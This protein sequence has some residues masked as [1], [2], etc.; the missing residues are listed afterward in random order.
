VTVDAGETDAGNDFI[1][2]LPATISGSIF[3]DTDN[4]DVGEDLL[5]G[6]TVSLFADTNGDGVPDGTALATQEATDGTYSFTGLAPGSYVVVETQPSGY[7]TVSDGDS[8]FPDTG[9]TADAANSSPTDNQIPVTVDAGETDAGNDFIEELPATIS[10]SIF[11]DTDND[12]VGEDLLPGVT[13]SLFADTNGDGVP[14]GSA[15]ATQEATDGTYSFTGLA[16]GDYVVVETQPSGYLTVS[17]EDST[18]GGDDLANVDTTDNLIPVSVDAG[19][20]D[21][22]N[23]FIEELPAAISGSIY[24]DTDNDDVGEDLLPG[25]TVSLFADTNGDGVPDGSALATQEAT[26]GT[27]SFTGLAPGSYVVVETQPSGYLTVSDGDSELPDTGTTADAANS[28]PTDN[29]IPVTVDAGETDAGNDFIEELPATI[30]GSIYADTNNDDVGEDLLPGVT[31][32]LFADTNGDGVPDGSALATQESTD[33]TY[34]FTGLAAGSYV[35][36]E[37]QPSGYLTVS[38]GDS[39]LPDTGTT[40]DAANSSP[41]DNQIPVTVDAGETDAGNDFIEE[42]SASITGTVTADT[43]GDDLGDLALSGIVITLTD[44]AGSPIDGD[45][46]TAGVQQ[47]TASTDGSGNYVFS[48]LAPGVYGV[49][50]GQPSGYGTISDGDV[51]DPGDD[52]SNE[53]LLDN[54]IP[55]SLSAGE[56]DSGNDFLEYLELAETF[57]EFQAEY[58]AFLGDNDAPQDNPDG[59][60]YSNALEYAFGMPPNS[61]V[62]GPEEFCL[63]KDPLT[64]E[65][66][67]QFMR[68]R[69]G[70]S[71]ATFT[72]EAAD[73]LGIPT[74]W[75]P[76]TSV[77]PTVNTTDPDVPSD[78]EKVIY[79]NLQTAPELSAGSISGVVR[80]AVEIDGTTYYTDVFG[81]QCTGYRDYEC[82]TYNNPFSEKPVYSS[83]F[84]STDPVGISANGSGDLTIDIPDSG[85][86]VDFSA[87]VGSAGDYYFQIT[88]G[89]LEGH[90]FDILSGGTNQ[91]T[92]VNDPDLFDKGIDTYNTLARMPTGVELQGASFEVIRYQT[93]DDR[94]DPETVFAG[95]EDSD[96][97]DFTRIL[98]YDSRSSNPVFSSLGLVG[99]STA[100]SKWIFTDDLGDQ[101]DQGGLRLDPCGGLWVHPK[102]SG[103][104]GNPSAVPLEVMTV[105]MVAD[106][107]QACVLNTGFNLVGPMWP[108]DQSAAGVNGLDLTV[109]A[110]ASFTGGIDPV[111]STELLFWNGDLVAD[112]GSVLNYSE[113]YDSYM[114][115]DGDGMQKWID[116]EDFT[117]QN[118]DESLVIES[119]RAAFLKLVDGETKEAHIYPQ[120]NF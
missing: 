24:A 114:L 39:E 67:A 75:N 1:E 3:A 52:P 51:T 59:D 5:P 19:E 28:S 15:L 64:G 46:E 62:S 57:A 48:D 61:G 2:E 73:T 115:L 79:S 10:G 9:T 12:D 80:L 110:P 31:V 26:D 74:V 45:P 20:T 84:S 71:D 60:I 97:S 106:H 89:V 34:S 55:V 72:L 118:L 6:V 13:V 95:E 69:G 54:F 109:S 112:D 94:F 11:A 86:V 66:S 101:F 56:T 17:D 30:S 35:V 33:G 93:I 4:D 85:S 8:I 14:D 108:L 68:R 99:T 32:S 105:G 103:D 65:V 41:I 100:D 21:S 22:G 63:F 104:S 102:S 116:I 58:A 44:G 38:D 81:W 78:S 117:L 70:L 82:A 47:I 23:D 43:D 119:H 36:V 27:Y 16:A 96:P 87:L 53:S 42:Q 7:L 76:V 40:S 50:E 37:T 49:L 29:Q 113:G 107:D 25:V 18:D 111:S 77:T 91:L 120:P 88:S 90:R 83:S 98:I 92:L